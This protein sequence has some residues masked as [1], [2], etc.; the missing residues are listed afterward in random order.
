MDKRRNAWLEDVAARQRNIVFPDTAQNETRFW[1][2]LRD[3]KGRLTAI[4]IIGI[5]LIVLALGCVFWMDASERFRYAS[6]PLFDRLVAA[7]SSWV[8]MFGLFGAGFL[9]LR[10]RVRRAL[11]LRQNRGAKNRD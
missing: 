3:G 1:R 11:S 4:Q 8:I 9:F 10:W 5:A 2:N 7:F 6:G